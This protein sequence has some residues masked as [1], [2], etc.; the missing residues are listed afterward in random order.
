MITFLVLLA[1]AGAV[2]WAVASLL[3]QA[4][5]KR[6][7][8]KARFDSIRERVAAGED[9]ERTPMR[10]RRRV[11]AA[12]AASEA[13]GD[14]RFEDERL[15]DS[16]AP[17]SE[18]LVREIERAA[19]RYELPEE[20]AREEEEI[21]DPWARPRN[22]PPT[23]SVEEEAADDLDLSLPE[24]P[25]FF[26][27][28]SEDVAQASPNGAAHDPAHEVRV[29]DALGKIENELITYFGQVP[30]APSPDV[31]SSVAPVVAPAAPLVPGDPVAADPVPADPVHA[32]PVH[33]DPVATAPREELP[34]VSIDPSPPQPQPLDRSP[35]EPAKEP[36]PPLPS[37]GDNLKRIRGVGPATEKI[38]HRL[39]IHRF[40]QLAQLSFGE[41]ELVEEALGR[42]AGRLRRE[43]WIQQAIAL[44][45]AGLVETRAAGKKKSAAKAPA[46]KAQESRGSRSTAAART[47]AGEETPTRKKTRSRKQTRG[48]ARRKQS[49]RPRR[50]PA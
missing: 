22:A 34:V 1:A 5:W 36:E 50:T 16:F 4:E 27:P 20:P 23:F 33:A 18:T 24:P 44:H 3:E 32:D 21:E 10:V 25:R 45:E 14:L 41:V 43:R 42:L 48:T 19:S 40:Q 29:A 49:R 35:P 39:D 30:P 28:F 15:D 47:A 46:R 2:C 37:T 26:P 12:A 9:V 8:R 13:S 7:C 31:P 17:V 6:T 11:V 38:L